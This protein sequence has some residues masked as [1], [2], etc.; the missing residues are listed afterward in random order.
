MPKLINTPAEFE[1]LWSIAAAGLT[2]QYFP[3]IGRTETD[4]NTV[5]REY[6]RRPKSK[7]PRR[8][9]RSA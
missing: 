2:L 8:G 4:L 9:R 5:L 3:N 1:V 6:E 7:A